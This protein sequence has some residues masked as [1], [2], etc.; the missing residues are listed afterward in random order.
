MYLEVSVGRRKDLL[1][2]VFTDTQS[3]YSEEKV[4]IDAVNY[5]RENT[6]LYE[7]DDYPELPIL[8]S[9]ES[10][11]EI[12]DDTEG[13]LSAQAAAFSKIKAIES[14]ASYDPVIRKGEVRVTKSKTFEA[15]VNLHKEFPNKKIAVLNFAS[16]TRPGGGVKTGSSAQEESLCRC[17]TL[18]PTI[19]RRWLWQKYYD[20]N[21]N[22]HDVLHSDAC[23]Y[24]PGVII[25]KTDDDIPVRMKKEDFVTVDVISCAAPNLRNEPANYQN[26]E[27]GAPVRMN[28]LDLYNLHV[29]RARHILHVAAYNKVDIL[30]LGAFGCGAF[31]NDPYCVAKAYHSALN[32]YISRFDLIEFAI[33]CRDYE[34]ENYTAFKNEI[35][36]NGD[37]YQS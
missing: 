14:G 35:I 10:L 7:A 16:A 5:G 26:P 22:A 1:I 2:D 11:M 4:L 6:C 17:S 9:I 30:I 21:R 13:S 3:F 24:S 27:T 37:R 34:T 31:Q 19:D 25:C 15:A 23:I 33:Y 12:A 18:Y 28:P 8:G 29:K 20:V 32:E 36:C